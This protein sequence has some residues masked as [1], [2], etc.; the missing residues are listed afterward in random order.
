MPAVLFFNRCDAGYD[1]GHNFDGM[2]RYRELT[3]APLAKEPGNHRGS[4]PAYYSEMGT[5]AVKVEGYI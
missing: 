3:V 5:P 1:I 2:L 4:L